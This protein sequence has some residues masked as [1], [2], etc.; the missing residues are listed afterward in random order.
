MPLRSCGLIIRW[1]MRKV[2]FDSSACAMLLKCCAAV[3]SP[4]FAAA[5]A[6]VCI[7]SCLMAV[8]LGTALLY[9]FTAFRMCAWTDFCLIV[10]DLMLAGSVS[11]ISLSWRKTAHPVVRPDFTVFQYQIILLRLASLSEYGTW[12]I[13]VHFSSAA[14]I[15]SCTVVAILLS[16]SAN[17]SPLSPLFALVAMV[18]LLELI[19]CSSSWRQSS[20]LYFRTALGSFYVSLHVLCVWSSGVLPRNIMLV[21]KSMKAPR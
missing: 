11:V 7:C 16:S 9:S 20:V 3:L 15:D 19:L 2:S 14:S 4:R 5:S 12:G 8:A 10:F 6:H 13:L 21:L 1:S 18:V 17:C